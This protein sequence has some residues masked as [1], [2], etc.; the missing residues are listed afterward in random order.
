MTTP[1]DTPSIHLRGVHRTFAS[2]DP[3][4]GE[5]RAERYDPA[6]DAWT[7]VAA[8]GRCAADDDFL[9]AATHLLDDL[10]AAFTH[11]PGSPA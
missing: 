2:P 7:Q 11:R 6:G 8:P 1:R 10:H 5:V 3:E 9:L 4:V